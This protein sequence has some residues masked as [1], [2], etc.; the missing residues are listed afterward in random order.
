MCQLGC[1]RAA[2]ARLLQ[3]DGGEGREG[4]ER[5][6]RRAAWAQQGVAAQVEHTQRCCGAQGGRQRAGETVSSQ[7]PGCEACGGA[8]SRQESVSTRKQ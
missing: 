6:D 1:A 3:A 4:G 5:A 8:E 7:V 2:D